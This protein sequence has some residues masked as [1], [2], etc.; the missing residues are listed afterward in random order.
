MGQ[1]R[2]RLEPLSHDETPHA[3]VVFP[4]AA[5]PTR[6]LLLVGPAIARY[7]RE[8]GKSARMHPYRVV[9]RPSA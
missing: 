9:F 6:G 7:I 2:L 4:D 5:R 8:R 3:V 1:Y